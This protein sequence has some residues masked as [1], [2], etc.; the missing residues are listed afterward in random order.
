[1]TVMTHEDNN[2]DR[3][4]TAIPDAQSRLM[5]GVPA[6]DRLVL[7]APGG[8]GK[9]A[10]TVRTYTEAMQWFAARLIP[11]TFRNRWEQ[12]DDHHLRRR[13]APQVI[14]GL[15]AKGYSFVTLDA[16]IR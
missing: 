4:A 10:R 15:R 3:P 13:R 11:H 8:R 2:H 9:A 5:R 1:M 14:S 16:L 6:G 7:A 12:A